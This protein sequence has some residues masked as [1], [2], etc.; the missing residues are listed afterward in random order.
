MARPIQ[1]L[2]NDWTWTAIVIIA[3]MLF[4]HLHAKAQTDSTKSMP[5]AAGAQQVVSEQVFERLEMLENEVAR[6]NAEK[7]EQ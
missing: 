3:L 5:T 2:R 1:R 7:G 6:L 4:A